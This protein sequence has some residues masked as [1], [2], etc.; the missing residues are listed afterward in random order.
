M[1]CF[2]RTFQLEGPGIPLEMG[3]FPGC[4]SRRPNISGDLRDVGQLTKRLVNIKH[5]KAGKQEEHQ[6][7]RNLAPTSINMLPRM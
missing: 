4:C 1:S 3:S 2:S 6:P 7:A 5:L